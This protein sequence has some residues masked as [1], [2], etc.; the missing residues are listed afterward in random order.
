M[1]ERLRETWIEVE[2]KERDGG[3]DL[4]LEATIPLPH[5]VTVWTVPGS[6]LAFY[7][8]PTARLVS[9]HSPLETVH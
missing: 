9:D 6:N 3:P 1:R 2:G 4:A 7:Y 5:A 8:T